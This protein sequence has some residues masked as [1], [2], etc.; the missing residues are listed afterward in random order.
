M[1]I[2]NFIGF[3]SLEKFLGAATHLHPLNALPIVHPGRGGSH[4]I[5]IDTQLILVSQV[6]AN[7][8]VL[9]C[10]II[11]G[12][13]QAIAGS[14]EPLFEGKNY[15]ARS[16]SAWQ[17]VAQEMLMQGFVVREALIA[18]PQNLQLLDGH[19]D[20]LKYN[21]ESDLYERRDASKVEV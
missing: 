20:C 21:K 8:E 4:G 19:A 9:Y 3:D 15:Q 14:H 10:R 5:S 6:Q 18:I 2:K 16:E 12:R 11:T 7:G 13:Y 1:P 17:I